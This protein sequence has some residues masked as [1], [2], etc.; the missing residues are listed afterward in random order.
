MTAS[1]KPLH[2]VPVSTTARPVT[3]TAE[4][5]VNTAVVRSAAA[6]PSSVA[7]G[8]ANS[9]PPTRAAVVY[10]TMMRRVG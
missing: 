5:D 2:W 3:V 9:N 7:N 4:V 10:T 1:P 8:R 6:F